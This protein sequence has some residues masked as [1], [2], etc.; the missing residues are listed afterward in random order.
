MHDRFASYLRRLP[1]ETAHGICNAHLLRNLEEFVAWE[2]EPDGWAA[3]MQALLREARDAAVHWGDTTGGQV[4]EPVRAQTA[5]AWDAL[6]APVLDHYESLPPPARGRHRG[7]NLALWALRDTCL[8][9]LADPAVPFANNLAEQA[10]RMAKLQ[11]K[12][13][14]G[15][16]TRAGVERFAHM[17][18]RAETARKQGRNF[19]DL[20]RLA[21]DAALPHANPARPS[22]QATQT[23]VPE[24]SLA[25]T[26]SLVLQSNK[27]YHMPPLPP[28]QF[29]YIHALSPQFF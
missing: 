21:P 18:G 19:L 22:S 1:E 20:L 7:H 13:S 11:M 3:R 26:D 4:P 6:L 29:D 2:Q 15:F 9:F 8:L 23:G 28:G 25:P 16:R 10:L 12:I 17:R 5:A 27:G 24:Q 14:G